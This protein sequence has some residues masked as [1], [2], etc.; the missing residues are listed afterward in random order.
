A[1]ENNTSPTKYNLFFTQSTRGIVPTNQ[2]LDY[3][4]HRWGVP[5]CVPLLLEKNLQERQI[6][7]SEPLVEYLEKWNSAEV[8]SQRIKD[9]E[10]Y[11]LGSAIGNKGCHLFAKWYIHT[12][13]IAKRDDVSFG[14]LSY[15]L[16]FDSNAGRVLFRTGFL[17]RC[18]DLEEYENWGVIQR[19]KG[20]G[21]KHY[22][23]V[24]NIRGNKSEKFSRSDEVMD[25]YEK[26][27]VEYL[28]VR[29]RRPVK[30]EIQRIP[31]ALLLGTE[32]GIGDLD[33]GLMHIGTNYCLNHETPK[34][35]HCPVNKL[36]LSYKKNKH[37]ITDFRT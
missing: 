4:I 36:C 30:I 13:G 22:L 12:F 2:V 7:S 18:A 31:N 26:I 15:E 17:T 32:Y 27:C 3:S 9:H 37:L 6:E 23:R 28:K 10:R 29:N 11:G 25:A 20:K 24:T 8:M 21:S 34:C 33:D 5:L 19:D 14:A 35:D 16:P 1:R